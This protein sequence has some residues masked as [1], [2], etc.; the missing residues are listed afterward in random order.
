[1]LK[2]SLCNYGDAY[3]LVSRTITINGAGAVDAAK[4]VDKREKGVI[5]KN[6]LPFTD[7]ISEINKSQID[8]AKYIDVV[9]PMYNLIEYSNNYPKPS[10]SL[11]QYYRDEQSDNI[12]N[13]ELFQFQV[14]ITRKTPNNDNKL[15]LK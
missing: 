10:G 4:K 13:S 7:C 14:K 9:M 3:I 1:M 12:V 11:W 8:N 15:M 2:P 5:F 6:C